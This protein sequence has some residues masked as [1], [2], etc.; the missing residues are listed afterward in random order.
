MT[1]N[2][3]SSDGHRGRLKKRFISSGLSAFHDYEALELLLSYGI[4]RKDTKAVAKTLIQSFGSLKEVL[5]AGIHELGETSGIGSHTAILIHLVKEFGSLYLGQKAKERP[6]VGCTS[7]LLDYCRTVSGGYRNERFSVIC[8]DAQNRVIEMETIQEGIV[9]Q[10]VVYPRKVLESALAR[11]ASAIILVHNH[12]SGNV[13]PSDAD[14]R[15]TKIICDAA[16]VLD[17]LVHDHL[18]VGGNEYFSF[19]EGG[20]LAG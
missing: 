10:A 4:P 5:D 20:L 9:N 1:D 7:E 8:L 2:I 17:I 13:K 14:I 3:T 15:L 6:Q 19:R 16:K 12:P 18:I 11:R